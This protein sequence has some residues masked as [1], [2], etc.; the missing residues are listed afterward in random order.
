MRFALEAARDLKDLARQL[1]IGL[2]K[3]TIEDNMEV[4]KIEDVSMTA[5]TEVSIDN[6]LTFIPSQYIITSQTG[7]ALITKGDTSWTDS[8][9]YLKNNDS[10]ND[11]TITV[12]FM[13]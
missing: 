5:N 9:L 12:I 3:L 8:T 10:S 11:A 4:L 7:N 6:V 1:S 13:R 2:R